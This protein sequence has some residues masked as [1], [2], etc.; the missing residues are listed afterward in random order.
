MTG[1]P[2]STTQG[3]VSGVPET[4]AAVA[5]TAPMSVSAVP[6][7]AACATP[8]QVSITPKQ[9]SIMPKQVPINPKASRYMLSKNTYPLKRPRQS[10]LSRPVTSS[11]SYHQP[12]VMQY[13]NPMVYGDSAKGPYASPMSSMSSYAHVHG[14]MQQPFRSPLSTASQRAH[15]VASTA[16]AAAVSNAQRPAASMGNSPARQQSGAPKSQAVVVVTQTVATEAQKRT[17]SAQAVQQQKEHAGNG[18]SRGRENQRAGVSRD[19][20]KVSGEKPSSEDPANDGM[21]S[22]SRDGKEVKYSMTS[23]DEE[24]AASREQSMREAIASSENPLKIDESVSPPEFQQKDAAE[25]LVAMARSQKADAGAAG[26]AAGNV[27]GMKTFAELLNCNQIRPLD[28]KSDRNNATKTLYRIQLR[29][30]TNSPYL[31]LSSPGQERRYDVNSKPGVAHIMNDPN[32]QQLLQDFHDIDADL[33]GCR[34]HRCRKCKKVFVSE[35]AFVEHA[36]SHYD[37]NH[38]TCVVCGKI[39]SRSWLLKGHMRTHTGEKPFKCDHDGCGKA[40]ADRSN[41]RSHMN[42]HKAKESGKAFVCEYCNRSFAQK[43]YLNKHVC[44]VHRD[45]VRAAVALAATAPP[46]P[47]L[48]ACWQA[49]TR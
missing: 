4:T 48:R 20:V 12:H 32:F 23:P 43:R 42:I 39:F 3:D 33:N 44:E 29:P 14:L 6:A 41:L 26:K 7:T 16:V 28:D 21:M 36:R 8:K 31:A 45:E 22:P 38:K 18:G 37:R 10:M 25:T 46:P 19:D 13:N 34:I 24:R 35:H 27:A 9:V 17:N 1:Y 30:G 49:P 47:A 11:T 15:A 40:F 5:V 2:A